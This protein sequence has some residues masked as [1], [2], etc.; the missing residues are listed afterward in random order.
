MEPLA[1]KVHVLVVAFL[2]LLDEV[3]DTAENVLLWD[4]G[5]EANE[6]VVEEDEVAHDIFLGPSN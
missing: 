3:G 6:V 4:G 1:V 5:E 2:V